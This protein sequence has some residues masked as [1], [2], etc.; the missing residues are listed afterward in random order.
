[1]D[2]TPPRRLFYLE[3]VHIKGLHK[4]VT[5]IQSQLDQVSLDLAVGIHM[6]S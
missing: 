6:T 1:M 2:T 3:F 4:T 5:D